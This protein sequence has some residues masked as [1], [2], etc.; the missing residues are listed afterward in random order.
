MET[1]PLKD[2]LMLLEPDAGTFCALNWTSTLIWQNLTQTASPEQLATEIALKF[3]GVTVVEA[4]P[5]VQAILT[6][7]T[8]LGVVKTVE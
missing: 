7:M 4:L 8:E 2:G 6:Q 5:E 3:S 1:A